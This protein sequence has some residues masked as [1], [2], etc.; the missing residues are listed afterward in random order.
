MLKLYMVPMPKRQICCLLATVPLAAIFF[1][2]L[3]VLQSKE[4]KHW[5]LAQQKRHVHSFHRQM[6]CAGFH[7]TVLQYY[8]R[9]RKLLGTIPSSYTVTDFHC[10]MLQSNPFHPL[11]TLQGFPVLTHFLQTKWIYDI[12]I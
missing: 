12:T 2:L 6:F 11:E 3:L 8:F 7:I 10:Q 5:L 9:G 1:S 4:A